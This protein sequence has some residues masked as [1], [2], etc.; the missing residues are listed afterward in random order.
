MS[1]P[2]EVASGGVDSK[3][4]LE[5]ETEENSNKRVK[6]VAAVRGPNKESLSC[7]SESEDT[8]SDCDCDTTIPSE[9]RIHQLKARF[10][11]KQG[12]IRGT[13][14]ELKAVYY[15]VS[16]LEYPL[17]SIIQGLRAAKAKIELLEL[18]LQSQRSTNRLIWV[19][20]NY[21]RSR[22]NILKRDLEV[23]KEALENK[24]QGETT[25]VETEENKEGETVEVSQDSSQ[26]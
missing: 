12:S 19:E 21:L 14:E 16:T 7:H 13:L 10:K 6:I 20:R 8:A 11:L 18:E 25:E 22:V 1:D 24:T 23:T 5:G 17:D 3:R 15:K 4:K 26:L 9:D 2:P